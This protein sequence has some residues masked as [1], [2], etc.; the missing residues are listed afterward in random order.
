[1]PYQSPISQLDVFLGWSNFLALFML[2]LSMHTA[3]IGELLKEECNVTETL[4]H[5]K[6]KYLLMGSA[7]SS[8]DLELILMESMITKRQIMLENLISWIQIESRISYIY[9]TQ[10]FNQF[11]ML[12]GRIVD[13]SLAK[14]IGRI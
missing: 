11:E 13:L 5:I 1:M 12:P 10:T 4:D 3:T 14:M 6:G 8:H 2:S 7:Y 9:D